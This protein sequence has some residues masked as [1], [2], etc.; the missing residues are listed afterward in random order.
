[1]QARTWTARNT[2]D[3][4]VNKRF[5]ER[6]GLL[7]P[8]WGFP[9]VNIWQTPEYLVFSQIKTFP[10]STLTFHLSTRVCQQWKLKMYIFSL[11]SALI[12][13]STAI[14]LPTHCLY[15]QSPP[16]VTHLSHRGTSFLFPGDRNICPVLSVIAPFTFVAAKVLY[17]TPWKQMISTG[18]KIKLT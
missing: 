2:W 4:H 5:P 17:S 10:C 9:V 6:R 15:T 14:V 1:M 11:F 16:K 8:P 3:F 12:R 13:S 7:T 18:R